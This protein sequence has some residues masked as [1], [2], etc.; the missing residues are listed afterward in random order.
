MIQNTT[1]TRK[2]LIKTLGEQS[3]KNVKKKRKILIGYK[4]NCRYVNSERGILTIQSIHTT[5]YVI[6]TTDI[7]TISKC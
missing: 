4:F 5:V 6:P 1:N 3:E 7:F 2:I